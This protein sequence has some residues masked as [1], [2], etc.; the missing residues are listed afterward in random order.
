MI[1]KAL[2]IFGLICCLIISVHGQEKEKLEKY[3]DQ[4]I[5]MTPPSPDSLYAA[6]DYLIN[7]SNDTAIQAHI[8]GYLFNKFYS[9][10]IMG[11]ESVAIHIAKNYFLNKK[12]NWH[13]D[14]G[15]LFLR[16]FVE[17][18]E[19][20]LIGMKA[21]ELILPDTSGNLHSLR[22]LDANYTVI[23]FFDTDCS[24]CQKEL[25]KLIEIANKFKDSDLH[26]YAVYTQANEN[27]LKQFISDEFPKS[28]NN[29]TFVWDPDFK[30]GFHKLYNVLKTPQ[31]FLLDRDK[32]II[33]RNLDHTSLDQLLSSYT[34][35]RNNLSR[36]IRAFLNDYLKV[37]KLDDT[38]SIRLAIEPLFIKST[39]SD[40]DLY[41]MMFTELFDIL[42]RSDDTTYQNC[43]IY[44]AENY[45][46][47]RKELWWDNS[48]PEDYVPKMIDRIKSNK[49]GAIAND[50][51]F[52]TDKLKPVRLH[53]IN[54]K[55]TVLYFYSPKCAVCKPFGMDLA[56]MYK[57]LH[58]KGAFILAVDVESR[59]ED[60]IKSVKENKCPWIRCFVK[61]ED[62]LELFYK[63]RTEEVPMIYLLD[64]DKKIIAKKISTTKLNELVK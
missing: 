2:S 10:P 11:M 64:S 16:L 22:N 8:A 51:I 18:N 26:V 19:N 57:A 46:Q 41:R 44:V 31:I 30:S 59:F 15:M 60:F 21:P 40:I 4:Y 48:F 23:Y 45:I 34:E 37:V 20:S 36:N 38:S 50:F 7:I 56:D 14:D 3:I 39:E 25:P 28:V 6:C 49:I 53:E 29:W 35:S 17:F 55:Y 33:G 24:L 5:A 32:T 58:K 12:L 9:S 27:N 1:R 47:N 61:D 54:A 13:G 43:A 63:F 62:R 52:Y 42:Q